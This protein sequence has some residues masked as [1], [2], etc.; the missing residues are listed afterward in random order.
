MTLRRLLPIAILGLALVPTAP[1]AADQAVAEIAR[2]AP[3]AAYGGWEAWSRYDE[4]TGR[5]ALMVAAPGKPAAPAGISTSSRP[6]DLSLGPDS[7]H[8]VA[9]VYQRCGSSGCDIRRYSTASGKDVQLSSVSSPSYSEA[10]PAIW[11]SNVVFTRRV[12]GC[13]VPYVKDLSSS[14]SSRRLLKSKCLQTD[15]GHVSIRGTRVII[16]SVDMSGADA[17]GAGIKVAELRKYSTKSSGSQVM[18]TQ[19][20][21]EES[22]YFG[23]VAQDDNFAYTVRIGVHPANTFMRISYSSGKPEEV[24]AFRTLTDGFAKP[25]ANT[26]LYVE[27]QGGEDATACDG[28][29]DI[30]CRIVFAPAVPFGGAQR[31]LTSQLTVAYQGQPQ[32]G[33]PLPFSG[34][35]TQQVVAGNNVVSTTPLVGV[36]VGL[37][38]RTGSNPE[39]F[40]DIGLTALTGADGSY[41]IVLPAAAGDPW[42]TAAAATAPVPTW[43]GR[44]TEGSVA[45]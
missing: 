26:S 44:G 3:V 41:L 11:G 9:A 32:N 38:H 14:A 15:A 6:F 16:S 27:E 31:T 10:T 19:S 35:L 45:P 7:N 23:Q 28:F 1:A 18:V 40:L 25:A 42:Y 2:Q 4:P 12:S 24:R 37:Y 21:G 5:Y 43:A 39:R 36:P 29:T 30:P 8:N 22:N 33:Q 13:D 20:F 34:T 17:N